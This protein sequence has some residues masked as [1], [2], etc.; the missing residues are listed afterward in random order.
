MA[1]REYLRASILLVVN[2]NYEFDFSVS[3]SPTTEDA[4]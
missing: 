1:C 3:H 2:L 4:A